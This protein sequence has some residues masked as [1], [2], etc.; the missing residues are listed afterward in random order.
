MN[1][2][3]DDGKYHVVRFTRSGANSTLQLD[4]LQIQTKYPSGNNIAVAIQSILEATYN[5]R[6]D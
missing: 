1:I 4:E 6:P 3:V 5:N 2:K